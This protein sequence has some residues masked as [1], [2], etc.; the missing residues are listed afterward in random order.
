MCLTGIETSLYIETDLYVKM[1][2]E[3][4]FDISLMNYNQLMKH[5]WIAFQNNKIC[6]KA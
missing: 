5:Y 1:H 4:Y 2:V 3:N 6:C